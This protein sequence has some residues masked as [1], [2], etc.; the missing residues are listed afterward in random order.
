MKKYVIIGVVI[1]LII[2]ILGTREKSAPN[3]AP[4]EW[5]TFSDEIHGWDIKYPPTVTQ[6]IQRDDIGEKNWDNNLTF[7]NKNKWVLG[8][9]TAKTK[10]LDPKSYLESLKNTYIKTKGNIR[11]N[12][13]DFTV[14]FDPNEPTRQMFLTI[15]DGVIFIIHINGNTLTEKILG[16]LEASE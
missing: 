4:Q 9:Y 3:T 7:Y 8:L 14:G 2:A 6:I 13:T 1:I 10:F 5:N 16:S 12:D 11:V 15:K